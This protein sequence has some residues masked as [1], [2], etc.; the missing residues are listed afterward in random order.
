M[1]FREFEMTLKSRQLLSEI[2][3]KNESGKFSI[4]TTK[5]ATTYDIYRNAN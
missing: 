1:L 5:V 2:N 3:V 4:E